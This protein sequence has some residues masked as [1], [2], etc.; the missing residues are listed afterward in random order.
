MQGEISSSDKRGYWHVHA[1]QVLSTHTVRCQSTFRPPPGLIRPASSLHRGADTSKR[2][3]QYSLF[4]GAMPGHLARFQ[5]TQA[6]VMPR[7]SRYSEDVVHQ[8]FPPSPKS[9]PQVTD[10]AKEGQHISTLFMEEGRWNRQEK[11]HRVDVL[12]F[13]SCES[14][15]TESGSQQGSSERS[16]LST[17]GDHSEIKT[18]L[19]EDLVQ[20]F[21]VE[22]MD[23]YFEPCSP[24]KSIVQEPEPTMI[25]WPKVATPSP[26]ET[27]AAANRLAQG[28][29]QQRQQV[30]QDQQHLKLELQLHLALQLEQRQPQQ[31]QQRPVMASCGV[32]KTPVDKVVEPT[33]SFPACEQFGRWLFEQPRGGVI[34]SVILACEWRKLKPCLSAI[35]AACT[36]KTSKLRPDALRPQ[37]PELLPGLPGMA[38]GAKVAVKTVIT[39]APKDISR[40]QLKSLQAM[41]PPSTG[42][43]VHVF[44]ESDAWCEAV[45][46]LMQ[47]AVTAEPTFSPEK[48]NW[49]RVCMCGHQLLR[50]AL[51]CTDCGNLQ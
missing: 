19:I 43:V 5:E 47:P 26:T 49:V 30:Q 39:I 27:A 21:S 51:F 13:E 42:I 37:L 46:V 40:C 2:I 8:Q 9:E 45:Q 3:P 25:P 10:A 24:D 15:S 33:M 41:L 36:G 50:G 44:Q 11:E 22:K 1:T 17:P 7:L 12:R 16:T 32:T 14:G 35:A 6:E 38:G 20:E 48:E 34:P 23:E 28:K 4:D 29:H 31:Q 18:T